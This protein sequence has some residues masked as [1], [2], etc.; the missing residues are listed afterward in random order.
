ML[1]LCG[2][3][4]SNYYNKVKFALLEKGVPF[5]EELTKVGPWAVPGLMERTPFGKVPF[6]EAA[7]GTLRPRLLARQCECA[8][9]HRFLNSRE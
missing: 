3:A 7:Q 8:L 2:F 5:T 1:K 6:I 9:R 4:L